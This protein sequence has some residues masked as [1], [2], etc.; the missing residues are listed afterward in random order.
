M[1]YPKDW[2][3]I[4]KTTQ[5]TCSELEGTYKNFNGEK[6]L[7]EL[8]G[9]EHLFLTEYTTIEIAILDENAIEISIYDKGENKT[10]FKISKDNAG[11]Y[12]ENGTIN[13]VGYHQFYVHPM[14]IAT[15]HAEIKLDDAEDNSLIANVKHK[16]YSLGFLIL[17]IAA[18]N[19]EWEKWE[20]I[21]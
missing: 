15:S 13:L 21:N 17:P 19:I 8:F 2:P 14:V 18:N 11:Y 10:K 1:P 6:Y 4:D 12:C 3:A 5:Q 16:S 20:R 9:I 7:S